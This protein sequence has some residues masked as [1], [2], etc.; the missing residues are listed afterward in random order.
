MAVKR[1][2]IVEEFATEYARV[3]DW[4]IAA[5]QVQLLDGDERK[6]LSGLGTGKYQLWTSDRAACV[7]ELC[8]VDNNDVCLLYLVAG[9]TNNALE[10]ILGEGQ[11]AVEDFAKANGCKGFYGI[12]RPEWK[13]V[14]KP[15][16]FEVV[17]V[18][19]YKEF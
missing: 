4:L 18:N 17:S 9:E 1:V 2:D 14:L 6:L 8:K 12:G 11:K 10:D 19:F 5:L 7:T 15:H 3:R 16:G 13:H